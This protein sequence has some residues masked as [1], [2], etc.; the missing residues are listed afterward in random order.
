MTKQME[1]NSDELA[2]LRQNAYENAL[3]A[4]ADAKIA[5]DK[6][7]DA[8]RLREG[9][10]HL[11]TG[12]EVAKLYANWVGHNATAKR[13]DIQWQESIANYRRYC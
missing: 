3:Q 5:W 2:E 6:Y 11:I 10:P 1:I 12:N 9:Y 4:T 13:C 7:N 8:A